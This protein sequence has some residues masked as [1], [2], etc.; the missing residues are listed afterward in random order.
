MSSYI[1]T[2]PDVKPMLTMD[3][4]NKAKLKEYLSNSP[5]KTH[6][7]EE[8][9]AIHRAVRFTQLYKQEESLEKMNTEEVVERAMPELKKLYEKNKRS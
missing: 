5:E 8:L 6:T 9:E 2:T 4:A 7:K 1:F 3:I